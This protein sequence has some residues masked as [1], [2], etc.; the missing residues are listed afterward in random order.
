M[1]NGG[2]LWI[3]NS[4]FQGGGADSRAIDLIATGRS[5]AMYCNGALTWAGPRTNTEF[6]VISSRPPSA[7]P[8]QLSQLYVCVA[9]ARCLNGCGMLK[10]LKLGTRCVP[11]VRS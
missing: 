3:T 6:H 11:A 8:A 1:Q 10:R 4:V 5:P 2:D 9:A 7:D